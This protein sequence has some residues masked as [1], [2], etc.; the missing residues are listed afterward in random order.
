MTVNFKE[1]TYFHY[2]SNG[3]DSHKKLCTDVS[4]S[5]RFSYSKVAYEKFKNNYEIN[6]S[7]DNYGWIGR[8]LIAIPASLLATAKTIYHFA[9]L[10]LNLIGLSSK[11]VGDRNYLKAQCYCMA[12]DL[13]EAV[14]WLATLVSDC[15]G[16][17]LVEASEFHKSCYESFCTKDSTNSSLDSPS[18]YLDA[19]SRKLDAEVKSLNKKRLYQKDKNKSLAKIA[20]AYLGRGN[21]EKAI[22]VIQGTRF[23]HSGYYRF[24]G[25]LLVK[26][27]R[28]YLSLGDAKKASYVA[29]LIPEQVTA[30]IKA[31]EAIIQEINESTQHTQPEKDNFSSY[32][33][34]QLINARENAEKTTNSIFQKEAYLIT[35][36]KEFLKRN[37]CKNALEVVE[38]VQQDVKSK[39]KMFDKVLQIYVEGKQL[40]KAFSVATKL[41]FNYNKQ[42]K[43]MTSIA[44][45]FLDEGNLEMAL[46]VALKTKSRTPQHEIFANIAVAYIGKDDCQRAMK[47]FEVVDE[48][49]LKE[50]ILLANILHQLQNGNVNE[51]DSLAKKMDNSDVCKAT[52]YRWC[53]KNPKNRGSRKIITVIIEEYLSNHLGN[54]QPSRRWQDLPD[55]HVADRV[56][57]AF[58]EGEAFQKTVKYR[59]IKKSYPDKVSLFFLT[60]AK[61][62]FKKAKESSFDQKNDRDLLRKIN[63]FSIKEN[64][65]K[66]LFKRFD[67]WKRQVAQ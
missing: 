53:I 20:K 46:K 44:S 57:G 56:L 43:W 21:W 22:E 58:D 63:N 29:V 60:L 4:K 41:V 47:F 12:R 17:Y 24:K 67:R 16:Q 54:Y 7:Y 10:L 33:T 26:L 23:D 5:L 48:E 61:E 66:R 50:K 6:K 62:F 35:I 65:T 45:A 2:V 9:K 51:A 18:T 40:D 30:I 1:S 31:K 64:N 15:Y 3:F 13:Q 32:T 19:T 49:D 14:G 8:K 11:S 28:A 59:E 38:I 36:A 27:A 39:T 34:E 55:S 37:D 25:D 42:F 52:V